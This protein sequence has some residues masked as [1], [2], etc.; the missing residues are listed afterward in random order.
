LFVSTPYN[1]LLII[2]GI[3]LYI[4]LWTGSS[5]LNFSAPI[6]LN[7]ERLQAWKNYM[8]LPLLFV[9]VV[10]NIKDRHQMKKLMIA[11][12]I[13]YV[14]SEYYTWRQIGITPGLASRGKIRGT[15]VWLGV[16]E[17]AAFFTQYSF[18]FLGLYLLLKKKMNKIIIGIIFIISNYIILFLFSR[19]AY[20]GLI[21]GLGA[22]FFIK[23][24]ILLIPLIVLLIFWQNILPS[25]VI[26][27]IKYT[28]DEETGTYESS[29]QRRIDIWE[30]SIELFQENPVTGVGYF[31][32]PYL[33]Y[34][35]GDTH[36][37][38]MKVLAEQGIIGMILLLMLFWLALKSTLRLYKE[39]K[40]DLLKGLGLGFLGCIAATIVN[41][42][43]G[44][45]WTYLQ[46][47][48]YFWIIMALIARGNIMIDEQRVHNSN[49]ERRDI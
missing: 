15:F 38:Y 47:G 28:K 10:N 45:R 22:I 23:K 9:I 17:V 25:E 36:N 46:L 16:N 33:G 37:L 5:Y 4:L 31:V 27:R 7:D 18:V 6:S 13:G 12:T 40:D 21:A 42:I 34:D 49:Q 48:S 41:N 2:M 30:K 26:E 8:I 32:F 11:L 44:D 14:I 3:Y 43:F 35:L 19:G 1:K 39:S 29:S 24:K 20:L